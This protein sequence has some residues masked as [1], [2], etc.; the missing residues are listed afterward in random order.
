M[1]ARVIPVATAI[2]ASPV[3]LPA[4]PVKVEQVAATSSPS[5]VDAPAQ[6]S[7]AGLGVSTSGNV[8]DAPKPNG[9]ATPVV[10]DPFAALNAPQSQEVPLSDVKPRRGRPPGGKNKPR[11][12]NPDPPGQSSITLP[13]AVDYRAIGGAI[14]H[15]ITGI[16]EQAIGPEW[17]PEPSEDKNLVDCTAAYLKANNY[18]DIPPGWL[19]LFA[20]CGYAIPRLGHPNTA[21]KIQ[22]VVTRIRG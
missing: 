13:D 8:Q 4:S 2:A 11:T 16:A 20:V 7:S 10:P 12:Y 21:A 6:P 9:S 14:V 15:T 3:P 22:N 1:P 18:A 5:A 19:L 17:K